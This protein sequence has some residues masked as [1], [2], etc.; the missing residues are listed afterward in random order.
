MQISYLLLIL[1]LIPIFFVFK[2]S[3]KIGIF[4][5]PLVLIVS[6]IG[7]III[8]IGD[9]NWIECILKNGRSEWDYQLL[10]SGIIS[11][12]MAVISIVLSFIFNVKK[13]RYWTKTFSI[14]SSIL[15]LI[16]I[17]NFS[18]IDILDIK[19]LVRKK[20]DNFHYIK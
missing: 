11:S 8:L 9:Y 1:I 2:K 16:M 17:I 19:S 15:V 14:I 4:N 10:I 7:L 13:N 3:L 5:K 6:L 20:Y 18:T 12:L